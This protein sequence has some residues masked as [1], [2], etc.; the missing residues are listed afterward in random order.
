LKPSRQAAVNQPS[1]KKEEKKVMKK[2]RL[3]MLLLAVAVLLV[4]MFPKNAEAIPAFSRKYQ[5]A[6]A[7]CHAPFPKLSA[8]GEAFRQ[9]GFKMP[10]GD[11]LYVKDKPVSQGNEAYEKVFPNAIW[12]SDIPGLPPLAIRI[13]QDVEYEVA[14]NQDSSLNFNNP[15]FK[16]LSAGS[17][18]KNMSFFVELEHHAA[19]LDHHDLDVE[20]HTE[21]EII[22]GTEVVT[23]IEEVHVDGEHEESGTELSAWLMWE[24]IFGNNYFNLR[25]GSIG[26]Q[27]LALPHLRGHNRISTT[28]YLYGNEVQ[29]HAH[30]SGNLG[31]ELN[32]F[33]KHFRYNLG[34]LQGDGQSDKKDYYG[35]LSLK[36]GGLGYDGSGGTTESG[37]LETTPAGYWR[38]D[39]FQIGLFGMRSHV[40]DTDEE[41]DRLGV[42]AR[43][44]FKDISLAA[45]FIKGINVRG[46]V[47]GGG[48]H[49]HG[50]SELDKDL[51]VGELQYFLF[52]W[53]IPYLRYESLTA[54]GSDNRDQERIT[55]GSV[56]L[57]R[58]NVK[59]TLEGLFYMKN[60]PAEFRG[61]K[62]GKDADD[63]VFLRLDYAF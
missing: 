26:M 62:P 1:I 21:T 33:G 51:W 25:M 13:I 40:G 39:S 57:A 23:G 27:D 28:G 19:H 6:C 50:S 15:E 60:D 10:D 56:F 7:T 24:N 4:E 17:L 11:E 20:I 36:F 5:T 44:S 30:G 41:F 48:A 43:L 46:H 8:L 16:L 61:S 32:G 55:V 59:F 54:D 9:N 31:V 22:N 49:G 63:R 3:W 58:S 14:G 38:D 37:K 52:P 34:L 45:G 2:F 47:H 18:G 12:P 42:D 35:A 53:M 29:L